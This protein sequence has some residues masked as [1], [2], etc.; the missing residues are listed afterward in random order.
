MPRGGGRHGRV[1]PVNELPAAKVPDILQ[2]PLDRAEEVAASLETQ[3]QRFWSSLPGVIAPR[4]KLWQLRGGLAR[5]CAGK[6]LAS[7]SER[8]RSV[9]DRLPALLLDIAA[10]S[11]LETC[12]SHVRLVAQWL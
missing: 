6:I 7:K 12:L 4:R 8:V 5:E 2:W 11:H 10:S 3:F 9:G 1:I